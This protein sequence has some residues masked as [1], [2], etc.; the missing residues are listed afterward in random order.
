MVGK[1]GSVVRAPGGQDVRDDTGKRDVDMSTPTDSATASATGLGDKE[2][3]E[4]DSEV[5]ATKHVVVVGDSSQME[6]VASESVHLVVT[7][8]PYFD[9]RD[10]A[11][12]DQIGHGGSL[13]TYLRSMKRV[14]QE[15]F[16]VLRPGRKFC[17]NISDL[18]LRGDD[19]VEWLPLGPL[20]LNLC[21]AVGFRL[22][23]RIV[24]DKTPKK[25][26]QF[27]SLPYPPSPL[28]CDSL[29][30]VY[31]L[32]RP[33]RPDYSYVPPGAKERSRL[34]PQEYKEYTKQ[35][36][37]IRRVRLRDN[38]DGHIAPFPTELP[39]RCIRL[40]SFVGD[41]VLDPFAGSGT[42]GQAA[43]MTERNSVMYE[44][45]PDYLGF[46]REK[47]EGAAGLYTSATIQYVVK[48]Q[49]ETVRV[50]GSS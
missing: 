23:D 32:R 46:I 39:L 36:W 34:T 2:T 1:R 7:S 33:G 17:L 5:H 48:G 16:R 15:C 27:G 50:G 45:N 22:A 49:T 3:C 20:V 11:T 24:W 18:P 6:V 9:A 8:P 31:I 13:E 43:L 12:D 38:M 10:Y 26:F 19:G 41:V 37:S 42:T 44:I 30:Y 21:L 25:G 47:V 4:V 28:I 40:Y 29:E 35:I 14:L